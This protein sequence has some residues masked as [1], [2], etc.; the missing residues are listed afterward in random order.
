MSSRH[1]KPESIPDH[2][3]VD[4]GGIAIP[5]GVV[6]FGSR[7]RMNPVLRKLGDLGRRLG[8]TL[9]ELAVLDDFVLQTLPQLPVA[10]PSSLPSGYE[11]HSRRM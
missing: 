7:L 3:V 11:K 4:Y 1:G 8:G 9:E 5:R 2:F 6:H 10:L